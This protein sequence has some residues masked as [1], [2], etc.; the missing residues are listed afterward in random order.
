MGASPVVEALGQEAFE[1]GPLTQPASS[2]LGSPVELMGAAER[3]LAL[4]SGFEPD[5]LS[6]AWCAALAET[7]AR[8][9]RA[10][11]TARARAAARAV[12]AGEHRR[13]GFA[14]G[15]GWLSAQTGTTTSK[16]RSEME[17]ALE[18]EQHP[19]IAEALRSGEVSLAQAGEIARAEAEVPGSAETLLELARRA[20]LGPVRDEVRK[21]V[22]GATGPEDLYARQQ[23]ARHFRHW[24]D[25]LG[26]VRFS[27]ALPPDVGVRAVNAIDVEAQRLR[28]QAGPSGKLEPFEAHA[29]DA[30]VKL[31]KGQGRGAGRAEVVI[32][33]DL[34]AYRRGHSHPGETAH[35]VG[36]GPVPLSVVRRAMEDAFVKAVVHDGVNPLRVAHFGRHIGAQLRT[37]LE[38]GQPPG[39]EGT[40]CSQAGC[41]RRYGLEWDHVQPVCR[42]GPTSYLNMQALCKPHHWEKTQR[43]REA[44]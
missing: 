2:G 1:A 13:R 40:R 42:D 12:R 29:A 17:A 19:A 14:D 39:F 34:W 28:R 6:T 8:T 26:M 21:V 15:P 30:V 41:P 16:A 11:A 43:D 36:G 31:L 37:A 24:T 7:L 3:L 33:V 9:E 10:C 35:I 27:G 18:A 44:S 20:G 32:V 38:L 22:L 5:E 4:L 25:E 23:K